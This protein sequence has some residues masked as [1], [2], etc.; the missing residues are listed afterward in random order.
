MKV[1]VD[2]KPTRSGLAGE[3]K[4]GLFETKIRIDPKYRNDAGLLEH[5]R[6]HA[7][8]NWL[9]HQIRRFMYSVSSSFKYRE[10]IGAY[11]AQFVAMKKP[12]T[13]GSIRR[14]VNFIQSDYGLPETLTKRAERDLRR[15]ITKTIK[16]KIV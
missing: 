1:S 2:Y 16:R 8:G 3:C 10:E 6:Y 7:R 12:T 11:A 9:D 5:E 4:W 14:F 13:R 15:E